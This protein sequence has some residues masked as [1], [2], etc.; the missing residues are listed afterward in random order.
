M[1]V[2]QF[3]CLTISLVTISASSLGSVSESLLT[4]SKFHFEEKVLEKVVRLEHKLE[5]YTE[6]MKLWEESISSSLD[7]VTEAKKLTDTFVESIRN[8]HIQDQMRFN[9][10]FLEAKKQTE[11]FV[12]SMRNAHIQDQMRFND[13]FLEAK[14]QTETFVESIRNAHIQDQMQFNDSFLEAVYH[15]RT[16]SENETW[17]YGRQM[18]SLFDSLSS[19]MRDLGVA[20]SKRESIM[21]SSLLRQ[22]SRFNESFDKI[23]EHFQVRFNNSLQEIEIK[24]KKVGFTSCASSGQTCSSGSFIKFPDVLSKIGISNMS[25]FKSS[26][27]FTCE[28]EGL[29][30]ISVTILS[31]TGGKRFGIYMNNHLV[32]KAY[33][34]STSNSESGTAVAVVVLKRNDKVSVQSLE[35]NLNNNTQHIERPGCTKRIIREL[36]DKNT[37]L[38]HNF[39]NLQ[40]KY[41]AIENE[42]LVSQKTTAKLVVDVQ[43][44]EQLKSVQDLKGLKEE[45]QSIRSQTHL[46]AFNQQARNQDFLALYNE[47]INNQKNVNHLGQQQADF[48]NQTLDS[49]R[50]IL[51][52]YFS[53]K[54][55]ANRRIDQNELSIH[56]TDARVDKATEK[57]A[58]T[59]CVS[60]DKVLS[61]G[62]TI[63]FN[64]V[65]THVEIDNLSSFKT[66]GKFNC[67]KDGLY[68]VSVWLLAQTASYGDHVYIYK[69]TEILTYT[70]IKNSQYYDTG[71]ATAAVE[72]KMNDKLYVHFDQG[73]V[74]SYGSCMTIIKIM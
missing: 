16:Q 50:M 74:D 15:F 36:Q 46:L 30:Q 55:D 7:K 40:G 6:K 67:T 73:K 53:F 28:A 24:Q 60:A 22:Q 62:E 35:D 32:S 39:D 34:S 49:F 44:L 38:Q 29:Y 70:F 3:I 23:Y 66:T 12:E 45:V 27:K 11:T 59:S 47:T 1:F 71:P 54:S 61:V 72:L 4:C 65:H 5:V 14:K 21:K 64:D 51:R 26:G 9:D 43:A 37:Q 41:T 20:E 56:R 19:K 10:S 68:V 25:T 58:M 57:V 33:I 52:Y 63:K 42:L 48:K 8:A 17:I 2:L 13:S 31:H 18:N 69:N